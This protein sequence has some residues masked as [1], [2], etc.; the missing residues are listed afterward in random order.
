V[1]ADGINAKASQRLILVNHEVRWISFQPLRQNAI[2]NIVASQKIA[3]NH[4]VPESI[5]GSYASATATTGGWN[6][7]LN[8]GVK[9]TQG[10]S[11]DCA[12]GQK[13]HELATSHVGYIGRTRELCHKGV[14]VYRD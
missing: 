3:D 14:Q 6:K 2:A 10:G 9:S 12:K 8:K 5:F 13:V 4:I 1:R 11:G 7:I